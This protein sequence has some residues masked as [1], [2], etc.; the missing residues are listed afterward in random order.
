MKRVA[1][2]EPLRLEAGRRTAGGPSPIKGAIHVL[3]QS[4]R[5]SANAAGQLHNLSGEHSPFFNIH[6]LVVVGGPW[7]PQYFVGPELRGYE[8][9]PNVLNAL[10]TTGWLSSSPTLR[11]SVFCCPTSTP[12]SLSSDATPGL[13]S[14]PCPPNVTGRRCDALL[15]SVD[16]PQP[17]HCP[18]VSRPP[19][20]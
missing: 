15:L 12:L 8:G 4:G 17:P 10:A 14:V 5:Q 13:S 9:L 2:G 3:R 16:W 19:P 7:M 6:R 18:P 20:L 11:P 1:Q